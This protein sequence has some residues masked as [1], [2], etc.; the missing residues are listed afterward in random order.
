MSEKTDTESEIC[1]YCNGEG[2]NLVRPCKTVG[3]EAK[4]HS[5]CLEQRYK[6]GKKSCNKCEF[7]IAINETTTFNW[8]KCGKTYLGVIYTF[9]MVIVGTW[10]NII[11]AMGDSSLNSNTWDNRGCHPWKEGINPHTVCDRDSTIVI[12]LSVV[13]SL[14]FWQFPIFSCR[15]PRTNEKE[16]CRYNI[17][18]WYTP[19]K[20]NKQGAYITMLA[21]FMIS[22]L[23]L[24]ITHIFGQYAL[25]DYSKYTW[26]TFANGIIMYGW[27]ILYVIISAICFI[28]PYT[29]IKC[30]IKSFTLKK[31]TFG[32]SRLK[33]MHN[34][35]KIL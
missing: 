9:L 18:C 6:F 22:N 16:T 23:I 12:I 1:D 30:T 28:V 17:F 3:C 32:E 8:A 24:R 11:T 5:I 7:A 33:T 34:D 19:Y 21:M 13:L 29:I 20:S 2:N 4:I 31:T 27:I 35:S 26:Y 10:F 15:N 25:N 14:M